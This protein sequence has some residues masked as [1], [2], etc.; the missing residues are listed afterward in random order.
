V[1]LVPPPPDQPA[2]LRACSDAHL[3]IA[4]RRHQ[5]PHRPR[6]R[7][8]HDEVPAHPALTPQELQ[9]ALAVAGGATNRE[10]ASRLFLSPKLSRRT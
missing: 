3:V 1:A 6:N 8:A 2:V 4:D 5:A 7:P 10:A 9:I